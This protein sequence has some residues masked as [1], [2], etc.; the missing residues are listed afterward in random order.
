MTP[1]KTRKYARSVK[2]PIGTRLAESKS[3]VSSKIMAKQTANKYCA[4]SALRNESDVE[5]FFIAPLLADLGYGPDYVETKTSI[6][7]VS[8]G[9]GKKKKSYIPDYLAYTVRGR[10]KPVLIVDAKHPD[11][12]AEAGVNDA[13]LYAS[14]I[15]R[16]MAAPKPE[17]YCLGINGHQVLVKH[18]DSDVVLHS[19]SFGDFVDD[20]PSF[21]ALRE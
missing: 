20:N 10:V 9:K 19:L 18:Y 6:R 1:K 11:E 17:Q 7:E 4:P 3:G 15:R 16:K 12:S 14:V 21:I 5:Q 13:Q 2:A 8:V